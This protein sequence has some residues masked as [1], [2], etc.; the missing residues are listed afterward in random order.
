MVSDRK[1]WQTPLVVEHEPEV[2]AAFKKLDATDLPIPFHRRLQ[3]FPDRPKLALPGI[4][5]APRGEHG[6]PYFH[7]V[8]ELATLLRRRARKSNADS[9]M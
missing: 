6:C 1:A 4:D 2:H 7:N 5:A 9:T 8:V 3:R